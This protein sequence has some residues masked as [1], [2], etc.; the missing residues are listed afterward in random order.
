MALLNT[1]PD[2]MNFNGTKM[3]IEE[4]PVTFYVEFLEDIISRYGDKFWNPLPREMAR[5]W[6]A[7]M[8]KKYDR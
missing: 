6:S 4:Y 7:N 2:Y 8:G 3:G 1:H 5:F